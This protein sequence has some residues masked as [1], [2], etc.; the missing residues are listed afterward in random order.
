M[1]AA[2]IMQSKAMI[3]QELIMTIVLY[4]TILQFSDTVSGKLKLL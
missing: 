3:I 4:T 2:D 1:N